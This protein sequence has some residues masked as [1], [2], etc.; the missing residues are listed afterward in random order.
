MI[1]TANDRNIPHN[2]SEYFE[3]VFRPK[4][5]LGKSPQT[6]ILYRQAM[7]RFADYVG[8]APNLD[9]LNDDALCGFLSHR[10][11]QGR[12]EHTVDKERDKL[13]ALAN[14]AARKRHIE[15]F[16]DVPGINPANI[17]PQCWGRAQLNKLLETCE[18]EGG[19]IGACPAS[20][21]WTAMHFVFLHTGE[22][23]G[24]TLCIRWEWINGDWLVIPA[25][26]RK[27]RKKAM[28]YYLPPLVLQKVEALRPFTES[29][30]EV[31]ALPW[32][33]KHKSGTFYRRY[34]N[35]L[36][37]AGLPSGRRFKPQKLR[38]TFASYLESG[39]GDATEALAHTTRKTTKDSYLDPTLSPK[40][41]PSKI[42]ERVLGRPE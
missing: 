12:A 32:A 3:Q 2:L 21:W 26:A 11:E 33:R 6:S 1:Y 30:G 29:T 15:Q 35:L 10:L 27:G 16:P 40:E 38:V 18:S 39:G 13:V 4:K 31:F 25:Q 22:R 28:P 5:L 23:T 42:M 24:A 14:Y 9:D 37:R 8:R 17:V 41:P 36:K 7:A 20:I 34:T 19:L